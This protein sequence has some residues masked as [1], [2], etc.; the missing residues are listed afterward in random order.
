MP[1]TRTKGRGYQSRLHQ[2]YPLH[3]HHGSSQ[4]P[5]A[6]IQSESSRWNV[7]YN[8]Q[9]EKSESTANDGVSSLLFCLPGIYTALTGLGAGGG[10]PSSSDVANKTNA[11]LYGLFALVG[12][13]GG[14]VVNILRPKVC[15]MIGSLGYPLYVG[16]L[17]YYDR[18]GNAWFPLMSGAILGLTGGFLWSAAAFVQ[19]A[20]AKEED[21]ALVSDISTRAAARK[22]TTNKASLST[23][24]FSGCCAV[25][26]PWLAV[27]SL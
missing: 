24:A 3:R 22:R 26:A 14:T 5:R 15:L 20:Y 25:L 11:I 9:F 18:T 19:F 21:K 10:H 7:S 16:G 8:T 17:W 1:A 27:L 4:L 6:A 2:P 23:S 12:F 13:F